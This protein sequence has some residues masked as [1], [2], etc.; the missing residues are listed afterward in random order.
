MSDVLMGERELDDDGG[1]GMRA[2]AQGTNMK[3]S[4]DAGRRG[5]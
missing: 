4:G 3:S 2:K 5:T 1:V